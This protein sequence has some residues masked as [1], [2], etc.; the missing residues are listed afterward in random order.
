MGKLTVDRSL[1][2]HGNG[3]IVV[4]FTQGNITIG[5]VIILQRAAQVWTA[6]VKRV[7]HPRTKAQ[8]NV[9]NFSNVWLGNLDTPCT[10][11]N[12]KPDVTQTLTYVPRQHEVREWNDTPVKTA[13]VTLLASFPRSGSN[14][15][16][17]TLDQNTKRLKSASIY[18]QGRVSKQPIFLKSHANTTGQARNELQAL[19]DYR[20]EIEETFALT[21]DPRDVLISSF[22]FVSHRIGRPVD[23]EVFLSYDYYHSFFPP[24]E[25]AIIRAQQMRPL[26]IIQAYRAWVRHWITNRHAAG[27]VKLLRF[28]DLVA[29]PQTAFKPLFETFDQPMPDTLKGLDQKTAQYGDSPSDRAIAGGWRNAPALYAP[30][31][32]T[33]SKN[34]APEIEAIG[35][36]Q[37]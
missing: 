2:N 31:I 25:A 26:N 30:I 32:E 13:P 8:R 16:Q 14:F 4:D 1:Y 5:D 15:V 20:G 17:K 28:E 19:W 35:Y 22:D 10:L 21:R 12:V 29:A 37:T 24:T 3:Q 33:V 9:A 23:P 18:A 36:A 27:T 11:V 6:Q 7:T 34:L